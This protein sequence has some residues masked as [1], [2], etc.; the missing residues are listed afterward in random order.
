MDSFPN[1]ADHIVAIIFCV[2]IPLQ[3]IRQIQREK[4]PLSYNSSQKRIIYFSTCISL[5][6][7]AAIVVSVWLLFRRPV[8]EIGL[9]LKLNGSMWLWGSI[10]F[11]ALY[12]LDSINSVATPKEIAASVDEWKKRTPFMPTKTKELPLYILMCFCA[13]V[14]EEIVYRGYLVTYFGFFFR[15][16]EFQQILSIFLPALIFSIS[17]FY[18]GVKNIIKVFIM[19]VLFGYIF[20][21]SGSLVIVMILHFLA[22]VASGLLS[23]KYLGR[24]VPKD[25]E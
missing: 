5:F 1:W 17:H 22:N 19:S 14:F 9:T 21:Q 15:H 24:M 7:M 10:C 2:L 25:E 13:G 23:V 8:A 3:A 6:I 12:V 11:V 16:L 20:I 18:H 4:S